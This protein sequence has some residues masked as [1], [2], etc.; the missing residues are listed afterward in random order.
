MSKEKRQIH[1]GLGFLTSAGASFVCYSK[2]NVW[3][4]FQF[5]K[6]EDV[7]SHEGKAVFALR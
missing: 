7:K 6:K 1:Y 2:G 4:G 3:R 5:H